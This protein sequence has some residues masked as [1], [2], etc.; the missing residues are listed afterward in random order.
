MSEGEQGEQGSRSVEFCSTFWERVDADFFF[1]FALLRVLFVVFVL[2]LLLVPFAVCGIVFARRFISR[3]Q[4]NVFLLYAFVL[5]PNAPWWSTTLYSLFRVK[6]DPKLHQFACLIHRF[7]GEA[8]FQQEMKADALRREQGET[9]KT[10]EDLELEFEALANAEQ[11]AAEKAE[12]EKA[13]RAKETK[14]KR[15]LPGWVP[16][17]DKIPSRRPQKAFLKADK[18]TLAEPVE[19]KSVEDDEPNEADGEGEGEQKEGDATEEEGKGETAEKGEG[20]A[21]EEGKEGAGA[22]AGAQRGPD[23]NVATLSAADSGPA[24]KADQ[25]DQTQNSAF[26]TSN[27]SRNRRFR[28]LPVV[29]NTF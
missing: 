6:M 12:Q 25:A 2:V 7:W 29:P 23:S 11:E 5:G 17:L 19:K 14:T 15:H 10:L 24:G 21:A 16:D 20:E 4:S 8:R 18:R 22:G 27:G 26:W 13:K 9:G 3:T 28:W 1:D